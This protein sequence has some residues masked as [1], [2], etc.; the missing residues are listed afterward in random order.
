M[1]IVPC[2]IGPYRLSEFKSGNL[3]DLRSLLFDVSHDTQLKVHMILK[4][5]TKKTSVIG[6]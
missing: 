2:T 3:Q 1:K 5:K 4:R 6:W